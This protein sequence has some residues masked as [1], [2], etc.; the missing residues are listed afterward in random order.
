MSFA[1]LASA[2]INPESVHPDVLLGRKALGFTVTALNLC[3][4]GCLWYA[5]SWWVAILLGIIVMLLAL[6]TNLSLQATVSDESFASVGSV[7][8]KGLG[9]VC[10]LFNRRK[11]IA[12]S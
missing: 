3:I 10:N 8:G 11:A 7:I 4:Q 1:S 12:A 9:T 2:V 6:A 5:L